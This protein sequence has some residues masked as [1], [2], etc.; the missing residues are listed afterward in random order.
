MMELKCAKGSDVHALNGFDETALH[1][2]ACHGHE[3]IV[4]VL[5]DAGKYP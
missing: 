1:R 4:G 3:A 5:L 2:D